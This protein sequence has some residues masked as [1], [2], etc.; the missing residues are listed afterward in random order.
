MSSGSFVPVAKV[1]DVG[2]DEGHCV[3][4]DGVAIALFRKGDDIFAI[5]NI[6]PHQGAPLSEGC[7][8]DGIVT[9][10]LHAW[11]FDVE[12]GRKV[13]G[14]ADKVSCYRVKIVNDAVLVSLG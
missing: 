14:G 13:N 10:P 5:N 4:V 11:E 7:Y 3:E 8:D 1:S 6:C 9:C 2:E 12:T